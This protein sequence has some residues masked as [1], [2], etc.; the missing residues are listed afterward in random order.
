MLTPAMTA[1][2]TSEPPV[3]IVNAFCTAVT[4]PS[5]L[6]RLPLAEEMT[7]GLTALCWRIIGKAVT[8]LAA[9]SV[10]PATALLRMKS[11]RLIFFVMVGPNSIRCRTVDQ[12]GSGLIVFQRFFDLLGRFG[13]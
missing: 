10:K 13:A 3:I 7:S 1:S 9:A 5:C 6:T 4:L 12:Y 2:S 11:R 8:S